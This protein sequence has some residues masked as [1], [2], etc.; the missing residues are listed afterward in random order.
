MVPPDKINVLIVCPV[1]APHVGGG[2]QYFPLL[3]K[4]L[5]RSDVVGKIIVLTE[6]H[7][8][9]SRVSVEDGSIVYRLLPQRDSLSDKSLLYSILSFMFTY[10]ILYFSIPFLL[11]RYQVSILH[12]TRYLR[13]SFYFLTYLSKN[14]FKVKIILDMRTTVENID[15]LKCLFGVDCIISNSEAVFNQINHAGFPGKCHILV[16]NPMYFPEAFME[17]EL[18]RLLVEIS[19]E[20]RRPYLLFLGQLLERKSIYE[21][22]DAFEVFN[23]REPEFRLIIA[24]R[25]M[26]GKH[27]INRIKG[28]KNAIYVGPVWHQH[29]IALI[30]GSELVLQPSKIEGI[31]RV[32]L[33]ALSL[34]KKVLLPPCVPEFL[35]SCPEFCPNEISPEIISSCIEKILSYENVPE[36]DLKK[37]EAQKSIGKVINIYKKVIKTKDQI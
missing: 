9:R 27:I 3:V 7:S 12:Y 32:S 20:I 33:E 26:L 13:R 17:I 4:E 15:V 31:P 11:I 19:S 2:G 21:I 22:L 34:G 6:N 5:N 1:Y 24:G 16:E 29:A 14:V 36:Y 8:E 18:N 10:C 30:Q 23:D 28:I 25:N 35:E 37:H